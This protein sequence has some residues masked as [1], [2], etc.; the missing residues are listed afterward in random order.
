M[1]LATDNKRRILAATALLV[2][3]LALGF[4]LGAA[5]NSAS[6]TITPQ[7]LAAAQRE[8]QIARV[9]QAAAQSTA[10]AARQAAAASAAHATLLAHHLAAARSC[11]TPHHNAPI[12]C[13]HAALR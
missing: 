10:T 7:Q 11:L 13:V 2:L 1:I 8:A 5:T 4:L 3:V 6:H 9:A 12:H